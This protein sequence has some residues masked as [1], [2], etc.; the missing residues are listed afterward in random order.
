MS[1]LVFS[2][3]WDQGDVGAN[4]SEAGVSPTVAGQMN[5]LVGVTVS[6]QK[7]KASLFHV[8]YVGCHETGVAQSEDRASPLR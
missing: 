4:A 5:W 6:R 2:M 3:C 1:Q 8:V 7:A